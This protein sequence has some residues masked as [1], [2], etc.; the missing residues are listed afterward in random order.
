MY[1][2]SR[3]R[4]L[5]RHIVSEELVRQRL[6]RHFSPAVADRIALESRTH[7]LAEEQEVSVLFV[8]IRDFTRLSEQLGGS[9]T[10]TLLNAYL[11]QVVAKVFEHGGTLDKFTGDGV[12]AYFGVPATE[13]NHAVSAISCGIEL[14]QGV[15]SF[16]ARQRQLGGPELHI[17]IGIHTGRVILGEI[18]STQRW[19]YTIIGDAVNVAARVQELTKHFHE[20]L[21]VTDDSHRLASTVFEFEAV[22]TVEVRGKSKPI[23]VL[24]PR[25]LAGESMPIP[26]SA[27]E[28]PRRKLV[29]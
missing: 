25:N 29:D 22:G 20:P 15:T 3:T 21:L 26:P 24:A 17:G 16:N 19:E 9:G 11:P 14:L 8:D 12:L 28:A 10:V 7:L 2:V 27:L 4:H 1:A 6:S 23:S 5:I 18:G 13:K